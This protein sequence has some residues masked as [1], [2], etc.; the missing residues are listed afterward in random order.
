MSRTVHRIGFI[1]C[2]ALLAATARAQ[3]ADDPFDPFQHPPG[4]PGG[5]G[6][7]PPASASGAAG[8]LVRA[9]PRLGG[10]LEATLNGAAVA[11]PTLK[12]D[13]QVDIDGDL[14]TVTV[15][16]SF[17]NPTDT[18][19]N[20][21]YVFPLNEQAAVYEMVMTIGDE[22]VMATIDE[23]EAA[24]KTF[25]TA[26]HEGRGA[27]LLSQQRPN[28]FTQEIANL[29]PEQPVIVSIRYVH[30]VP[31][32]DSHYEL[33]VPLIVGPR[34]VPDA[35]PAPAP[36]APAAP[37]A[38]KP[39]TEVSWEL[40]ELPSPAPV[41]GIDLPAQVDA[42]RVSISIDIDGGMP[43]VALDSPSHP[44]RVEQNGPNARH[45][46][47]ASGRTIDNRDFVLTYQL[48][49]AGVQAGV[50]AHQDEH[51]GYFSLLIEP[52]AEVKSADV[53][54]RE[55]VFV[56][57][58][59]GSMQGLPLDASKAFMRAALQQ[60]RPTDTF[61][62]IRFSDGATEFARQPLL[63]T[64]NQVEAGLRYVET[65][66]SEGGTE[67][68]RGIRQALSV[69]PPPGTLRL[70]VF[71]TDGYIG[72]EHEILS[73]ID[74]LIGDARLYAFGVGTAVNRYLL[75]EMSRVGR[76]FTRYMD[77]TEDVGAVA[78]ELAERINAPVLTDVEIDWGRLAP[79]DVYP[80]RVTDLF[81]GHSLRVAGRYATPG[82]YDVEVRG[83]INGRA[84]RLP[85][86]LQLDGEDRGDAVRL[87]WARAAIDDAMQQFPIPDEAR[88]S[89]MND[90]ALK[91]RVTQ[92]GLDYSLVTRW[93]AFV[94]T[95]NRVVNPLPATAV[96]A[97]VPVP[98][99]AGVTASAY[100]QPVSGGAAATYPQPA[101]GSHSSSSSSY[102]GSSS[103]E[104]ATLTGLLI[105]GGA[106]L[107]GLRR[108]CAARGLR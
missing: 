10:R 34:Y 64:P 65:L 94:A 92:L 41:W 38:V 85:L 25:E 76:G 57:D 81:A 12:T 89:G 17:E 75:A 101:V 15:V 59:S 60:L 1:L 19:L 77:P 55:V 78:A 74:A 84:A 95:S 99:V 70:V 26:K 87:T 16:Q 24:R 27:A 33:V 23:I 45:A 93:T 82:T 2:A 8:G 21:T 29:M 44:L 7:A 104:P 106:A 37:A 43:I 83:R 36:A 4:Q 79:T 42:E 62:I 51:G 58:C 88:A 22:V 49:A 107:A 108:R 98:M 105:A 39:A 46:E 72:N 68:Q 28:M 5:A 47:L 40:D 30:P 67:M 69:A 54:P 3:V 63:A 53:T 32:I 56:L 9:D 66:Q 48:A 96:D 35:P 90:G 86:H 52:P 20:A 18:P 14:A 103:P 71:L 80:A 50:L 11:L 61:R 100:G 102:S 31:R 91:A 73:L 97:A 6:G 13:V